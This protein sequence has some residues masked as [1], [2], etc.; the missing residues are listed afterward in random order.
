MK[1]IVIF[2]L[3]LFFLFSSLSFG[4]EEKE[5]KEGKV[6]ELGKVIVTATKTERT[7][8]EVPAVV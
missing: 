4:E 1:K 8:G 5:E 3:A 2:T 7:V 6:L